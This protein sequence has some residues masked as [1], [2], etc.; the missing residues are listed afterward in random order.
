MR[1]WDE[2]EKQAFSCFSSSWYWTFLA[3]PPRV[4]ISP[5][6]LPLLLFIGRQRTHS[7]HYKRKENF[8][9]RRLGGKAL[10]P[11]CLVSGVQDGI[12]YDKKSKKRSPFS[13]RNW[14][15]IHSSSFEPFIVTHP[16]PTF[17]P[18]GYTIGTE[19]RVAA[20]QPLFLINPYSLF[21]SP[22][23]FCSITLPPSNAPLAESG[24]CN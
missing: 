13:K 23:L 24:Y 9:R 16:V 22:P 21:L 18:R 14:H 11:L 6:F 10:L 5:N 7:T 4:E 15:K 19:K 3:K 12:E 20:F 17:P 2:R 8:D 1:S